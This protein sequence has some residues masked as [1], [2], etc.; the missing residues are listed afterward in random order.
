MEHL[1]IKHVPQKPKRHKG[2]IECRI[3]SDDAIFLLDGAEDEIFSRTMFS[4]AAPHDLVTA[5]TPAKIPFV[6]VVKHAAQIEMHSLV[7]QIQL[8]LHRQFWV[9]ELSFRFCFFR[10]SHSSVLPKTT[11]VQSILVAFKSGYKQSANVCEKN[12]QVPER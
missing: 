12:V 8:P 6:Q 4:S 10:P 5:K 7:T 3:N 11:K 2:L 9:C 1:V